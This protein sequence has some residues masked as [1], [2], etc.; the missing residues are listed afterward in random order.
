MAIKK[1]LKSLSKVNLPS[2]NSIAYHFFANGYNFAPKNIMFEITHRCNLRCSTCWWWRKEGTKSEK[3]L[4][5][6]MT[7]EEIKNFVDGVSKY[8][9]RFV[10]T[11]GEPFVR[12]DIYD[13][14]KY[15][16]SKGMYC[17]VIT[18]GIP[19]DPEK[20]VETGLDSIDISIDGDEKTYDKIRGE[21]NF[22]KV[23]KNIKLLQ[24]AREYSKPPKITIG[25]TISKQNIHCL[26]KVVDI[27]HEL[28]TNLIYQNLIFVLPEVLEKHEK[29]LLKTF[30]IQTPH[31]RGYLIQHKELPDVEMLTKKMTL[32]KQKA[33]EKGVN[34]SYYPYGL[35]ELNDLQRWYSGADDISIGKCVQPYFS[36]R[37]KPNGD[38][39]SCPR[40]NY[41]I[42]NLKEKSFMD[43]WNNKNMKYF[44]KQLRKQ[45]MF[46]ACVRCSKVMIKHD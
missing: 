4:N 21:G 10:I 18:N 32:V 25:C 30:N 12:K 34:V 31:W 37:V 1:T 13:I 28:K 38:V 23:I 9:P 24:K 7:F 29:E 43:I 33:K 35:C 26:D 6:E 41:H 5:E 20:V 39:V 42:G 3:F 19:F 36:A 16:K 46:P 2:K 14:I 11:G 44:R 40:V 45:K 17:E 8:N 15:I 22:K 27:A